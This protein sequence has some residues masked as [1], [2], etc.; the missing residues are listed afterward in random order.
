MQKFAYD[1]LI[2]RNYLYLNQELQYEIR[3]T[4][5]AFFGSGLSSNIA[6]QA[7][8]LGF[9]N[10]YLHDGDKVELSNLN[11]QAFDCHDLGQYKVEALRKKILEINPLCNISV[12]AGFV[13]SIN[14]VVEQIDDSDVVINTVDCTQ[15]Y[16][17]II[18]YARKN[19]KLVLC[20]FNPGFAGLVLCF[21]RESVSCWDVFDKQKP[22]DDFE[23]SQQLFLKYPEINAPAQAGGSIEEFLTNAREHYFPQI[24]IG[25][26]LASS[27]VLTA[28]IKFLKK[29]PLKLAPEIFYVNIYG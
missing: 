29:E 5:L 24:N 17:D 25:A 28:M 10:M 3:K 9:T 21:S 14:D 4:K 16:F 8:R 2:S 13:G 18:E 26:L 15:I 19:N 1:D 20:P 12:G 6:L 7:T 23:I 22:L 27:M 11:R